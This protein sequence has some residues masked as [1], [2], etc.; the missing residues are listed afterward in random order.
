MHAVGLDDGGDARLVLRSPE[1]VQ[2]VLLQDLIVELSLSFGVEGETSDLTFCFTA[3]AHVAVVFGSP[4]TEFDDVIAWVEFIGEIAEKITERGL[5]RRIF[6]SLDEHDG[7]GVGIKNP[8]TEII[9]G[10]VGIESGMAGGE[11]G[12]EDI[13]KIF[14][15]L[16]H[17]VV[18]FDPLFDDGAYPSHVM[19]AAVQ[20]LPE[21]GWI[22][23]FFDLCFAGLLSEFT[24]HGIQHEF[25]QST[26]TRVFADIGM[27][28]D[29]SQVMVLGWRQWVRRYRLQAD[30][31]IICSK[32]SSPALASN[33]RLNVI[34]PCLR[35]RTSD[36]QYSRSSRR[37]S[38][39]YPSRVGRSCQRS[40]AARSSTDIPSGM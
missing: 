23:K 37:N 26:L 3:G 18:N 31:I 10:A 39:T 36:L 30:A 32:G 13:E 33:S 35:S 12:H 14:A 5:D 1:F 11:A 38:N 15:V 29:G 7:I 24:P 40:K 21:I 25:S 28:E 8:L 27:L 4:R 34:H 19:G 20:E 22:D 6:G 17:H 9:E 2:G 16:V